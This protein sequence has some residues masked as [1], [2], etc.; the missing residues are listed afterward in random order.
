MM[1]IFQ[2]LSIRLQDMLQLFYPPLCL[3]CQTIIENQTDLQVLCENC[4]NNLKEVHENYIRDDVMGRL[5]PCYLDGVYTIYEFDETVQV[6]IHE[7]KYRKAQKLASRLATLA[8]HRLEDKL[9]WQSMDLVIP[10]PLFQVREKERGFN[11]STAIAQGFFPELDF[12]LQGQVIERSKP[13]LSQTELNREERLNNVHD[14]F[15]VLQPEIVKGRN[16]TLVDD[17]VTTGATL[18][19]C[20][21]VLKAAGAKNIWALTLATPTEQV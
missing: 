14:A 21:R 9:P 5:N 4:L 11:Q 10:I 18:N 8:L 15:T 2:A 20:A 19:E 12:E 3:S 7:I 6:L 1:R 13:T 17:V 16:I